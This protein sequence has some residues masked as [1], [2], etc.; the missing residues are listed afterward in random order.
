MRELD[1]SELGTLEIDG[2]WLPYLDLTDDGF[3]P[4]HV[5][6]AGNEYAFRQSFIEKGHGATMPPAIAQVRAEGKRPLIIE[7]EDRYYLFVTPP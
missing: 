7:R 2:A 1:A 3:L 5:S 4:T 6:M